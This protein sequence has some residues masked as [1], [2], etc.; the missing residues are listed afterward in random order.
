MKKWKSLTLS[1]GPCHDFAVLDP[2]AFLVNLVSL[3]TRVL[4]KPSA[5]AVGLGFE[6]V[7]FVGA[8]TIVIDPV[9]T[10]VHMAQGIVRNIMEEEYI[11]I[12]VRVPPGTHE[13]VLVKAE[14]VISC[15]PL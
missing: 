10:S 14:P 9:P 13:A 15:L 11:P 5:P 2:L 12:L 6:V 7:A 1:L 3:N 8:V 4:I